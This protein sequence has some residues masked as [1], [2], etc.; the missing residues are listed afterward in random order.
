MNLKKIKLKH[1]DKRHLK[2]SSLKELKE[3]ESTK[4]QVNLKDKII[5]FWA[6]WKG[7]LGA[8][9]LIVSPFIQGSIGIGIK[10]IGYFLVGIESFH[11]VGRRSKYGEKGKF[12][13]QD[14]KDLY[15]DLFDLI[16][17]ILDALKKRWNL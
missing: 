14:R 1:R 4:I 9:A 8:G 6:R 5:F 12:T 3:I 2:P 11:E 7:L 16:L 17:R 13:K 15:K 10:V